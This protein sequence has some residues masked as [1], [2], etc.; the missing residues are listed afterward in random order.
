MSVNSSSDESTR[1]PALAVELRLKS[2]DPALQRGAN[3]S[4]WR[5][6]PTREK[7]GSHSVEARL[8]LNSERLVNGLEDGVLRVGNLRPTLV[9]S[10]GLRDDTLAEGGDG[11]ALLSTRAVGDLPGGLLVETGRRGVD[12]LDGLDEQ[13]PEESES[14]CRQ[15]TPRLSATTF[16]GIEYAKRETHPGSPSGSQA[17]G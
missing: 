7:G 2:N 17:R 11:H 10:Q 8:G 1:R 3:E 16:C 9:G 5:P 12:V 13:V 6:V 4:A 14:A 15:Q